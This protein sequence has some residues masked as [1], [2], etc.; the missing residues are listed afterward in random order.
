VKLFSLHYT[1]DTGYAVQVLKTKKNAI[2]EEQL[3]NFY[4]FANGNKPNNI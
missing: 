3:T 2:K 4:I 1:I